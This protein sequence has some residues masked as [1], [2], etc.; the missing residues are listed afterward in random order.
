MDDSPSNPDK[1]SDNQDDK[2]QDYE[3]NW[4]NK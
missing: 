4:K 1:H 2:A 3:N